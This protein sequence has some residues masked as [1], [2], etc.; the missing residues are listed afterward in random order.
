ME[1]DDKEWINILFRR[2]MELYDK[3]FFP[4]DA[5][6]LKDKYYIYALLMLYKKFLKTRNP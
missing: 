4:I 6:K 2:K 1:T 3:S 5:H